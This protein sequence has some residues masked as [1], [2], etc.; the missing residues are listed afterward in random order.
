MKGSI[1]SISIE[2]E[3]PDRVFVEEDIVRNMDWL[4]LLG[5]F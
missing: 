5:D 2:F 1:A 4:V 3:G